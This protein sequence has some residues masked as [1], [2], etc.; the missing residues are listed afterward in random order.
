M[1]SI[2]SPVV[3]MPHWAE[4]ILPT[5]IIHYKSTYVLLS[6]RKFLI[7]LHKVC[8]FTLRQVLMGIIPNEINNV[9]S[10]FVSLL[11]QVLDF[12][13]L[14]IE[15]VNQKCIFDNHWAKFL[16]LQATRS[17]L[18]PLPTLYLPSWRVSG[19]YCVYCGCQHRGLSCS[20]LFNILLKDSA[21]KLLLR[22]SFWI[23]L[24]SESIRVK[25]NSYNQ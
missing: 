19:H 11:E 8:K 7:V 20:F 25:N 17:S 4:I 9:L 15:E 2:N 16:L 12:T 21:I 3:E 10:L 6:L 18:W 14:L 23:T 5:S 1:S 13:H 22:A 24:L